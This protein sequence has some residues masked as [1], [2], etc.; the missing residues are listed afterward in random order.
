MDTVGTPALWTGFL[1]FV[2]VMLALD[3]G[4]FHRKEH[5]VSIKEATI[6]SLVWIGLSVVFNIGVY[7]RFGPQLGLEFTTGYLLEK[8]LSVDNIFVFVV[9]FRFFK[10]PP[11]HQHRV[12][13]WGILGALA[14]R[15]IFIV[16][17][18]AFV[19]RFHWALYAFGAILVFTGAKL[20]L[21]KDDDEPDLEHNFVLRL[22]KRFIPLS[23]NYEGAHF[24]VVEAGRRYATPLLLCLVTLEAT[25]LIFALDSIPAVFGVT[26]DPFI[27]F[28]SNIFAILGLRSLYFLL[29]G[30]LDKFRFL[31]V[32][33][34]FVLIFIGTKMLIEKLYKVPIGLSLAV[35]ALLLVGSIVLSLMIPER[36][37]PEE[38]E[39]SAGD[40]PADDP[41]KA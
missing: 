8:A 35:I 24:T 9:V 26:N 21:A 25:D 32:G 5:P 18:G 34:A 4:V 15:A 27:I 31:K 12:L 19:Q 28:T 6:W 13:Y 20:L 3:L 33:L 14:M 10:V 17:G 7:A 41:P 16:L 29:A 38:G 37:A 40:A 30:V 1:L 22:F 36:K 23:T 11:L 2:L 39:G